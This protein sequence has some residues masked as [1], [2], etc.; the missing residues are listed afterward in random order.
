MNP[1]PVNTKEDTQTVPNENDV[2]EEPSS[3]RRYMKEA[4]PIVDAITGRT[5][6]ASKPIT[7]TAPLS[8]IPNN[9]NAT[10]TPIDRIQH[11]VPKFYHMLAVANRKYVAICEYRSIKRDD[12]I[13][14]ASFFFYVATVGFHVYL[15]S[16]NEHS[17][18]NQDIRH[19][20]R[21][22]ERLGY[23]NARLPTGLELWFDAIGRYEYLP[24]KTTF[25]PH[26]PIVDFDDEAQLNKP[27]ICFLTL[28]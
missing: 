3:K 25:I 22:Y 10:R 28:I 15:K 12:R 26:L 13:D 7:I 19:L 5:E 27:H 24:Q 20:V 1:T 14:A 23:D 11:Y 8:W 9:F 16:V 2:V 18:A 6:E 17:A 4:P 21:V